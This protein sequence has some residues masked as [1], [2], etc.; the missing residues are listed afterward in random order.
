MKT[1]TK[2]LQ[3]STQ[4][5]KVHAIS[6]GKVAV[7]TRFRET[8]KRGL[9]AQISFLMDQQFTEWMPIWVWVIEHPEG[10]F[11]IDTGENARV[12]EKGYFKPAG[13]FNNWLN[14]TQFRF[15]VSREEEIDRQL[16][17]LGLSAEQVDQVILTHL[18]LDH[19]DGLSHFGSSEVLVNRLEWEKPFGDLPHLYPQG[20][21]PSL[22]ELSDSYEDFEKVHFLTQ[23][24][25]LML[26]HTPGHTHGHC[27]VLLRADEGFVLFAG[28]VVYH[29][30]QLLDDRFAG[31]NVDYAAAEKTYAAIKSFAQ[32]HPLV[33]LPS[34]EWE[35]QNRLENMVFF[36][37]P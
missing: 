17:G 15:E 36:P 28:D 21:S 22:V 18:H 19:V 29:Q 3:L 8:R 11:V 34:H 20:F 5:V 24:Q 35:A 2:E 37:A 6:T 9:A 7:K 27:S 31:G 10:S 25:S 32:K 12:N 26:V 23:D 16:L 30:Q 33:V 14:T 13:F 1:T 4:K